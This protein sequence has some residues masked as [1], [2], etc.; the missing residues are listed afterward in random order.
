MGAQFHV[1]DLF[2]SHLDVVGKELESFEQEK[3]FHDQK[4]SLK[5]RFALQFSSLFNQVQSEMVRLVLLLLPALKYS[6]P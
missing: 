2:L 3:V 4:G 1:D 6:L 5:S